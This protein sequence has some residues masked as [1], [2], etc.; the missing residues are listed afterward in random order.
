[1]FMGEVDGKPQS[2]LT[3]VFPN[4]RQAEILHIYAVLGRSMKCIFNP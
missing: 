1:M 3:F 4:Y 2:D